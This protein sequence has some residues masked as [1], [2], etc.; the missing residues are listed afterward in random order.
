M[1]TQETI[2]DL[3]DESLSIQCVSYQRKTGDYF[4]PKHFCASLSTRP[5]LEDKWKLQVFLT[6]ASR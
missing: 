2:Q 5:R 4:F 3:L 6:S 1:N